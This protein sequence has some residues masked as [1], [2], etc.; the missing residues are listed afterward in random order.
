MEK[1]CF[2]SDVKER[3][4]ETVTVVTMMT[5]V[6]WRDQR[7]ETVRHNKNLQSN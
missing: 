4:G 7:S 2:E 5:T 3:R 6:N 1:V